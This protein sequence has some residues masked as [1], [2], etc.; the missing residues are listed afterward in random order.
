MNTSLSRLTGSV[1]SWDSLNGYQRALVV[2]EIK[3]HIGFAET[4]E[5]AQNL[6]DLLAVTER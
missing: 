5:E 6:R 1:D 4:A 3:M 2:R